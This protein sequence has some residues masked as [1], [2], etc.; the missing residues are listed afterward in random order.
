MLL[1]LFLLSGLLGLHFAFLSLAQ[2][3]VCMK[4]FIQ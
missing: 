3:S 1:A 2:S 4:D